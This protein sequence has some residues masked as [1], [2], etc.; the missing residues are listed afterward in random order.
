[1][2]E[3]TMKFKIKGNPNAGLFG[4]TLGFFIGFAAVVAIGSTAKLITNDFAAVGIT[5][6][7]IGLLVA[8]PN[9]SGSLLRIPFAAWSDSVG[10]R[11]PILVLLVL[12]IIGLLGLILTINFFYTGLQMIHY[13]LLLLWGFLAGC[14]IA[15]F[16][17]GISQTSYWFPQEKQGK[18]LG[19]YAGIGNTA[20][21]I[22]S[23]IMAF[24]LFMFS[25]SP[26]NGLAES[27]FLWLILLI[28]GSILYFFLGRNAWSFQLEEQH[29]STE[30]AKKIAKSYGQDLFPAHNLKESL[31]ISARIWKTWI[32]VAV[33]FTSFGG[34]IAL[35]AWLPTYW[36]TFFNIGN[37][38][39]LR[40]KLSIALLLTAILIILG[41]LSRVVAGNFADKI[42]G[43]ITIIIG[44]IA[45]IGGSLIVVF[46]TNQMFSTAIIGM[47][48]LF[49]GMGIVNAG[50]FKLVPKVA[51]TAVGGTSGWVGGLGAFGG[52]V[53]PPI[54]GSFVD[55]F[56]FSGY[57]YGY[58]IFTFLALL[59]FGIIWILKIS[60]SQLTSQLNT[61]IQK[62]SE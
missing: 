57:A 11:K 25:S 41:S 60:S 27:Y 58:I 44:L 38:D 7:L 5:G 14:G 36:N 2:N 16:S 10:G 62:S 43:E 4:A 61:V 19:I 29:I 1:M 49:I 26:S 31:L 30:E 17:V 53:I 21:G 9:L 34:F 3:S 32:L 55:I 54:M 45:M 39:I 52:F 15:T 35:S 40:F 22:F 51:P 28:G 59:C 12:S 24:S 46:S 50:V 6:F 48:L 42:T 47:L 37:I 23:L 8:M 56:Q 33:Y 20:P 18:A 13:P